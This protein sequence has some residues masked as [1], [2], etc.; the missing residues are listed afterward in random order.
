MRSLLAAE[1]SSKDLNRKYLLS[2]KNNKSQILVIEDLKEQVRV[3]MDSSK[4]SS[5]HNNRKQI[6][7]EIK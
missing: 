3:C 5:I 1:E 2:E 7:I 6:I 4:S